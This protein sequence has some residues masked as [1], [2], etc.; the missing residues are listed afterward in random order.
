MKW[1]GINCKPRIDYYLSVPNKNIG[2]KLREG[3]LEIK[4]R[5]DN[6]PFINTILLEK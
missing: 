4:Y 1:F 2:I 5:I 3:K 6:Y